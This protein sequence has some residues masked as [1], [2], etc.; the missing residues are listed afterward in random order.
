VIDTG[1]YTIVRH[2]LYLA[3]IILYSGIPLAL[4]SFC[5]LFPV[6]VG[7]IALFVRTAWE[8]QLLQEELEGYKEYASRVRYR[9]IPGLW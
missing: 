4:A 7:T 3:S 6:V 5:A 8:D 2:P 9:L 1:P